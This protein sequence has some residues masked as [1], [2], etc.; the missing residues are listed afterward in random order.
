MIY[1]T[2]YNRLKFIHLTT[3][4]SS[5]FLFYGWVISHFI[6]CTYQLGAINKT[7]VSIGMQSGS[8]ILYFYQQFL[9]VP[10]KK[11]NFLAQF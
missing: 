8:N 5:I 10:F 2:L 7:T 9:R 1:F 6:I 11:N 3:L 4:D